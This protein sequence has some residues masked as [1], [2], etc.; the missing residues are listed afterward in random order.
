MS[1]KAL[2]FLFFWL[3]FWFFY[4]HSQS[5]TIFLILTNPRVALSKTYHEASIRNV[6]RKILKF[7]QPKNPFIPLVN[8]ANS[9]IAYRMNSKKEIEN[10][11]NNTRF[12]T[13]SA[14]PISVTH[15]PNAETT[16][17]VQ[18]LISAEVK[19]ESAP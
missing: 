15:N 16:N 12:Q 1:C 3:F 8:T 17:V 9:P 4:T 11:R 5:T 18:R 13:V 19:I 10:D 2:S 6:A 14:I 7:N